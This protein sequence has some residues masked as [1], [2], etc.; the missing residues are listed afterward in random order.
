MFINAQ[1]SIFNNNSKP[2]N[3]FSNIIQRYLGINEE[4]G[5][6]RERYYEIVTCFHKDLVKTHLYPFVETNMRH[7][8]EG[9][10]QRF[11]PKSVNFNC[12]KWILVPYHGSE[13]QEK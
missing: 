13:V 1:I 8:Q 12:Y 7:M 2:I 4:N 6:E 10:G 5:I 3:I 9:Q 11:T